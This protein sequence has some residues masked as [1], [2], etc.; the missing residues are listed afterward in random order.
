MK[1][2]DKCLCREEKQR[3][4]LRSGGPH[5]KYHA[6]GGCSPKE[7]RRKKPQPTCF[8]VCTPYG[9]KSPGDVTSAFTERMLGRLYETARERWL[10][11]STA[12]HGRP[13]QQAA[14]LTQ[15]R[16]F[17]TVSCVHVRDDGHVAVTSMKG[18]VRPIDK[19]R[20]GGERMARYVR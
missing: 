16:V 7:T 3:S 6:M 19:N 4:F 8:D 10:R 14:L 2:E 18:V 17:P 9:K 1:P 20:K 11:P 13:V 12:S 15:F 5:E